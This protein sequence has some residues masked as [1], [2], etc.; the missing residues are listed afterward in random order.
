M[1]YVFNRREHIQVQYD[2]KGKPVIVTGSPHPPTAPPPPIGKLS[3]GAIAG[4]V[5]SGIVSLLFSLFVV[6]AMSSMRQ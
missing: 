2:M 3:G 6:Y 1:V 4:L 5:I